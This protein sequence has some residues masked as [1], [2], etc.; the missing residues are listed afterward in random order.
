MI[1]YDIKSLTLYPTISRTVSKTG[2]SLQTLEMKIT[3]EIRRNVKLL[4]LLNEKVICLMLKEKKNTISRKIG[5]GYTG[6][7]SRVRLRTA[8]KLFCFKMEP[9]LPNSSLNLDFQD[10]EN[11]IPNKEIIKMTDEELEKSID[12]LFFSRFTRHVTRTPG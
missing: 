2:T 8:L 6:G 7:R 11:E 1:F 5:P 4:H 9:D 12:A 3:T 10:S